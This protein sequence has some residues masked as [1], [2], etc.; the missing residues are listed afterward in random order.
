MHNMQSLENQVIIGIGITKNT[1][2]SGKKS[3]VDSLMDQIHRTTVGRH[4]CT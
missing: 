3:E 4:R 2:L 1:E